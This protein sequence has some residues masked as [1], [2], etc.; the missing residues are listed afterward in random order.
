MT[1]FYK[2]KCGLLVNKTFRGQAQQYLNLWQRSI[3]STLQWRH[4]GN[5]SVSNQQSHD[6]LLNRLFR[7]RSKE[8]L[9]FRV[10]G[11]CAENSPGTGEFPAQTASNTA[12][13]SISWRHHEQYVNVVHRWRRPFCKPHYSPSQTSIL[14][15]YFLI[16]LAIFLVVVWLGMCENYRLK[17]HK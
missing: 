12:N 9:K 3:I 4:D 8:T 6:C 15:Q 1:R 5:G 7:R 10:T 17:L 14:L 2:K 13:V 16:N 11:L